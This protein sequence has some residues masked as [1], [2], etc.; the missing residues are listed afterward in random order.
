VKLSH[1][2]I[3]RTLGCEDVWESKRISTLDS[4]DVSPLQ[5]FAVIR[6]IKGK[7]PS[8]IVYETGWVSEQSWNSDKDG[9]N[10]NPGLRALQILT[11]ITQ[12]PRP[13]MCVRF[14]PTVR[15]TH[16]CWYI[17]AVAITGLYF[18]YETKYRSVEDEIITTVLIFQNL[19]VLG[20]TL[21]ICLLVLT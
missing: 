14:S 16:N 11:I 5:T 2:L 20:W 12:V 3:T 4:T 9:K 19:P 13:I 7:L 6:T 10:L 18:E 1:R 17:P 15:I 21:L 8:V